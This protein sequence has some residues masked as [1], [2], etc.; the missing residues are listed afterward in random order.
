MMPGREKIDNHAQYNQGGAEPEGQPV[1]RGGGSLLD[2]LKLLEEET[3]ARHDKT[4]SH[5]G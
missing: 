5:Q 2:K 1:R 4:E 3:E